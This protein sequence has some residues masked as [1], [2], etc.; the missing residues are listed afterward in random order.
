MVLFTVLR[1]RA[2]ENWRIV[3]RP[4]FSFCL[5]IHLFLLKPLGLIASTATLGECLITD[6]NT[7][8]NYLNWGG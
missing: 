6:I 5:V 4:S 1:V 7:D 2:L 3:I 8:I